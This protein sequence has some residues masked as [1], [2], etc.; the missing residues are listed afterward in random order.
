MCQQKSMHHFGGGVARP[1]KLR[2]V[3][4]EIL[5]E[6]ELPRTLLAKDANLGR[7]TLEAWLSGLRNPSTD[8]IAQIAYGLEQRAERLQHLAK[9]LRKL[10]PTDT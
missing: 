5:R 1:E 4:A 2:K 3:I 8:S 10:L 6:S 7:A 9:Q